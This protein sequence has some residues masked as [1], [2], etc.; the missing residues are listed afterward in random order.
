MNQPARKSFFSFFADDEAINLHVK[1][2]KYFHFDTSDICLV[3]HNEAIKNLDILRF[4][5]NC[6]SY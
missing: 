2:F 6:I 4:F 3:V 1:I 5:P